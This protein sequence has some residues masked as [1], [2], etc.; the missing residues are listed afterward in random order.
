MGV[1]GGS[2]GHL[3]QRP[4]GGS[5]CRPCSGDPS[6]DAPH[7]A[8]ATVT[9][10]ETH[11]RT[12]TARPRDAARIHDSAM[13]PQTAPP[14]LTITSVTSLLPTASTY[15]VASSAQLVSA[16]TAAT[17]QTRQRGASTAR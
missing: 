12:G 2:G 15:W 17:V 8:T 13:H 16:A 1:S 14:V 6:S 9:T 11:S 10:N 5:G 4:S 7:S 3:A